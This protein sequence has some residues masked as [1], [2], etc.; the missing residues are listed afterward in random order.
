MS[1]GDATTE[2]ISTNHFAESKQ[3]DLTRV[4]YVKD[5]VGGAQSTRVWEK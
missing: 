2:E 3:M 5:D 4:K 1:G